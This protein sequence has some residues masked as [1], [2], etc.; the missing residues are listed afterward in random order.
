MSRS[1]MLVVALLAPSIAA[2]QSA[3]L[4]A[5]AISETLSLARKSVEVMGSKMA[6]LEA[7]TGEPVLFVH[8]NPTS[9]YLWRNIIPHVADTHRAIAV[10][11]IGMGASDKSRPSLTSSISRA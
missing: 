10:D 2:A 9:S 11:L 5:P 1:I 6:Y 7:G 4:P 8:G 3:K